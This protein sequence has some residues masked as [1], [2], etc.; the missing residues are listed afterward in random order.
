[1]IKHTFE[2]CKNCIINDCKIILTKEFCK[3]AV[4]RLSK[5]RNAETQN[6]ILV[7]SENQ[8]INLIIWYHQI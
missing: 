5:N 2:Q 4:I 6:L 3:V 8:L 1:M 7:Y